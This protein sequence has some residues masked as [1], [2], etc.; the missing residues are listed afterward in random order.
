MLKHLYLTSIH[1]FH[2]RFQFVLDSQICGAKAQGAQEFGIGCDGLCG[3]A[4][5][6]SL[7]PSHPGN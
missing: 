1:T 7:A 3:T 4:G 2:I 5:R 6:R